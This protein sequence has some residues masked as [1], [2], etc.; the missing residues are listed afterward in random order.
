MRYRVWLNGGM[1]VLLA[2]ALHGCGLGYYWQAASGQ[3]ALMRASRPVAEVLDDPATPPGLAGRLRATQAMLGYAHG[4][5]HLPGERSYR[6]YAALDRPYVV[7]NVVAAPALSLQPREWCYPVVGCVSYRGYFRQ[8]DARDFAAR[9]AGRGDDVFV[10]GVLAYS[11]LGRFADPLLS[12]MLVLPDY[13]L[14]GLLFHELAHQ[15]LYIRDDAA[16]NE[17]FATVVEREGVWRWLEGDPVQRCAYGE[18]LGRLAEVR[19][20]LAATRGALA[21]LYAAPLPAT[22]QRGRKAWLLQVLGQ[23]YAALRARWGGPPYFD[24][25]FAGGLDNARLA[26]LAT[27]DQYVPALQVLLARS[28]GD[29]RRFYAQAAEL[30]ARP[31]AARAAA[32]AELAA[33]GLSVPPP[34]DACAGV[35]PA[36][37][38]AGSR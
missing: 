26:A 18:W 32:L 25:W 38:A 4:Q 31:M 15:Q 10:G 17:S 33:G 5:L 29:L 23:D 8:A 16:F 14:A 19:A 35:V 12:T 13:Q 2:L 9:Q 21:A 28:G 36:A 1:L 27:Y 11:T 34:G 3:L 37:A 20:L 22:V 24:G 30:G 7:W 6:D